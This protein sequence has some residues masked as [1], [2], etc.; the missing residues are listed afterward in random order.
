MCHLYEN[1]SAIYAGEKTGI[2]VALQDNLLLDNYE[3]GQV[4]REGNKRL[5]SIL[6]IL[7]HQ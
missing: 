7:S 5:G 4:Y 3:H 1:L 6:D 2:Q